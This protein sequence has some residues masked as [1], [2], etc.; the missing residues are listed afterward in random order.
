MESIEP[1]VERVADELLGA[2]QGLPLLEVT[3]ALS[4]PLP[5]QVIGEVIG[6]EG[7]EV[8]QLARWAFASARP[9]AGTSTLAD[10]VE[11]AAETATLW[12]YLVA[13]L[14]QAIAAPADDLLGAVARGI[15]AGVIDH[16]E[17]LTTLGILLSAGGETTTS[18]I[19]NAVR[20]LAERPELQDRLRAEPHLV[21]PYIEEVLRIESP[22]RFHPRIATHDTEL[23]GVAIPKNALVALLWGAV[24][25]D[26]A[27]WDDPDALRLDRP[28]GKTHMGFGR[29]IHFCVGAPLARIE[30]RAVL[31]KLLARTESFTLDPDDPPRWLHSLW[32][33]RHQRLP[34]A[35]RWRTAAAT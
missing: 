1:L 13:Q 4:N 12:P 3:G 28:N 16:G 35:V 20:L 17:A 15:D 27:V 34:L 24:N 19:G 6:F 31:T 10:M 11:C 2:A 30:A 29:G 22:F 23:G 14:N 7:V 9:G 26:P 21:V 5:M 25:R 8:D 18:L 33:R 32:F